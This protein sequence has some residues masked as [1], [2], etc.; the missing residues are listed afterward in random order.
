MA[1]P[2]SLIDGDDG[3][4]ATEVGV[5]ASEKH[6][7]LSRYLDASR[8][9][10]AQYLGQGKAGA[11]FV[12]LICGPGRARVR[13]TGKWIDGSAVAAWKI[14]CDGKAP[15]TKVLVAD[16]D[17]ERRTACVERLRRLGAPVEELPGS[18][19][20]AAQAAVGAVNPYG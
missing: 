6:T 2:S 16:L 10:R 3:L 5:W 13:D 9:A 19:V 18:A 14:S 12:D 11:A 17:E 20:E 4:P 15:F 1:S 7:Y 8:A